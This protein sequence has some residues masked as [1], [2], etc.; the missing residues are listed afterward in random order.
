M[1]LKP[2]TTAIVGQGDEVLLVGGPGIKI[3]WE[4]EKQLLVTKL[5]NRSLL[6]PIRMHPSFWDLC[7]QRE[8]EIMYYKSNYL[9]FDRVDGEHL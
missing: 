1:F 8:I 7:C 6:V 3:D 9:M 5:F 4:P 2:P